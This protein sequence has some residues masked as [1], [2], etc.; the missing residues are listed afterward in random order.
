MSHSRNSLSQFLKIEKP[1]LSLSFFLLSS[2]VVSLRLCTDVNVQASADA[3]FYICSYFRTLH[4][5]AEG[6]SHWPFIV[7][8]KFPVSYKLKMRSHHSRD[9]FLL[10]LKGSQVSWKA[11]PDQDTQAFLPV[12]RRD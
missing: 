2:S 5:F 4:S 9:G 1:Y 10:L 3:Q 12:G 7:G 11:N 6:W 8:E